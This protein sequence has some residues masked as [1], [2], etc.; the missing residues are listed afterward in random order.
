MTG[1]CTVI[2]LKL[3]QLWSDQALS[4]GQGSVTRL[5][6]LMHLSHA[7]CGAIAALCAAPE[8]AP[9]QRE[10]TTG[11]H[12]DSNL[13][14]P[15]RTRRHPTCILRMWSFSRLWTMSS[16]TFCTRAWWASAI[17]AHSGDTF[18]V[19]LDIH[20]KFITPGPDSPARGVPNFL[21]FTIW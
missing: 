16:I 11:Y 3:L 20:H 12:P 18:K 13:H 21:Y 5:D 6:A 19:R 15:P 1:V 8:H 4:F 17:S 10:Q 9:L 7:V 2:Y 14:T